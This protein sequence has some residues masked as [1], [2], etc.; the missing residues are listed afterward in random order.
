V[1]DRLRYRLALGLLVGLTA[2]WGSIPGYAEPDPVQI[3]RSSVQKESKASYQGRQ[4]T[5]VTTALNVQRTVQLVKRKAPNKQRVDYLQPPR[6]RGD[7]TLDDG[8]TTWHFFHAL[9]VVEK[10]ASG[11][12]AA[13]LLMTQLQNAVKRGKTT[14]EYLGEETI[15]GRKA[16]GVRIT[17]ARAPNRQREVWLD[18]EFGVVLRVRDVAPGGRVSESFFNR[19]EYDVTLPDSDFVWATPPGTTVV[20]KSDG[21]PIPLPRARQLAKRIW[22]GLL[23]PKYVPA[24]FELRS[25]HELRIMGEPVIHLRFT[26][27]ER[28]VSIFQGLV[29]GPQ[30]EPGPAGRKYNLLSLR[31]GRVNLLIV[32]LLP[33]P[34]LQKIA[35]S[36]P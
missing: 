6:L 33:V 11:A 13:R 31:R 23:L 12:K 16:Q 27:G 2:A 29:G 14:L 18:Q 5:T 9:G 8:T 4:E 28:I 20:A 30:P 35:D 26:D 22:G 19:I 17:N 1:R 15:A 25:A 7:I 32:G 3:V 10:S 36:I 24:H 34:E 21:P